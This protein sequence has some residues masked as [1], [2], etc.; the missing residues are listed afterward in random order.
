MSFTTKPKSKIHLL[1]FDKRLKFL[2]SGNEITRTDVAMKLADYDDD[3]FLLIDDMTSWHECTPEELNRVDKGREAMDEIKKIGIEAANI[4]ALKGKQPMEDKEDDLDDD[5][6]L[7]GNSYN[8][9]FEEHFDDDDEEEEVID[10]PEIDEVEVRKNFPESWIFE[11]IEVGSSDKATKTFTVPDSMTSW[12]ISAFSINKLDGLAIMKPRELSVKNEF[13]IKVNLPYSIRYKEILKLDILVYNYIETYEQLKVEIDLKKNTN[14]QV[15]Q[16]FSNC[17]FIANQNY[18]RI[19]TVPPMEVQKV[20]FFIR[21]ALSDSQDIEAKMSKIKLLITAKAKTENG[22]SYQD[23]LEKELIV[24]PIGLRLY[25]VAT[26]KFYLDKS[27]GNSWRYSYSG[28]TE[29]ARYSGF[30]SGNYFDDATNLE[31]MME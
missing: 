4:F 2:N 13:F 11:T 20:S 12:D 30:I 9:D 7:V 17:S 29:H 14:F 5:M 19:G 23:I 6:P 28:P 27:S 22:I 10:E 3:N 16:Y 8:E 24:E 1:A 26:S 18:S 25:D 21:A 31:S 15:V